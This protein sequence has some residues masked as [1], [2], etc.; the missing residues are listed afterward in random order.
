[1]HKT[2]LSALALG[3]LQCDWWMAYSIVHG[4]LVRPKASHNVLMHSVHNTITPYDQD[5]VD[6][7][8]DD[9]DVDEVCHRGPG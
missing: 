6:E 4:M 8:E 5:N 2:S 9:Q 1:M 7:D 3:L